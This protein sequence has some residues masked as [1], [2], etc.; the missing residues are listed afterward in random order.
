MGTRWALAL[1]PLRASV[2]ITFWVKGLELV[3]ADV[4]KQMG[5]IKNRLTQLGLTTFT[6]F[7]A[8][9]VIIRC[10]VCALIWRANTNMA[11]PAL[12]VEG[13]TANHLNYE[14]IVE[15]EKLEKILHG[16]PQERHS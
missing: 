4:N 12:W 2:C 15:G 16:T 10:K 3:F 13:L 5:I 6:L 14:G 8:H 9:H 7:D 11:C 1:L